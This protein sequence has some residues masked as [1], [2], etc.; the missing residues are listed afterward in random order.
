MREA[1]NFENRRAGPVRGDPPRG[2]SGTTVADAI[3]RVAGLS[4]FSVASQCVSAQST[5][6][7]H[8]KRSICPRAVLV[9]RL[10]HLGPT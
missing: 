3:L 9:P 6:V 8:R 5:L 2:R 10:H 1:R 4:P 7:A